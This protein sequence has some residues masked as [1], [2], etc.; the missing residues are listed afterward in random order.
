MRIGKTLINF[1]ISF[2]LEI[3]LFPIVSTAIEA[4]QHPIAEVDQGLIT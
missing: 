3:G 2:S 1:S 4:I